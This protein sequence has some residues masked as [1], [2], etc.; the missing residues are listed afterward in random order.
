VDAN[1]VG[2]TYKPEIE[3]EKARVSEA[4]LMMVSESVIAKKNVVNVG[5][6]LHLQS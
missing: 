4:L 2:Y 3:K 1:F 6:A 5:S